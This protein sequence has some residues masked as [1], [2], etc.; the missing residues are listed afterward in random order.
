MIPKDFILEFIIF[1]NNE[2][3]KNLHSVALLGTKHHEKLFVTLNTSL[4]NYFSKYL[5][6][7]ILV[8]TSVEIPPI[9]SL[10][11]ELALVN[12]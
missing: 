12:A 9:K 10:I 6:V 7:R 4:K 8:D 1:G 2:F 3:H 5:I 11:N